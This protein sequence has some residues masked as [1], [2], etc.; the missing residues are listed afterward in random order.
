VQESASPHLQNVLPVP[1]RRPI[2][3]AALVSNNSKA[4]ERLA[5][6]LSAVPSAAADGTACAVTLLAACLLSGNLTIAA[7]VVR[8]FGTRLYPLLALDGDIRPPS[9]SFR[10]VSGGRS[11][12]VGLDAAV[13]PTASPTLGLGLGMAMMGT[14]TTAAAGVA[15]VNAT[16]TTGGSTTRSRPHRVPGEVMMTTSPVLGRR[17]LPPDSTARGAVGSLG[18]G[19]DAAVG[20]TPAAGETVLPGGS[21]SGAAVVGTGTTV[22]EDRRLSDA[23]SSGAGAGAQGSS[24][25]RHGSDGSDRSEASSAGESDSDSGR[26]DSEDE[27]GEEGDGDGDDGGTDL[28]FGVAGA[29]SNLVWGIFGSRSSDDAAEPDATMHSDA[30]S[31]G[32]SG[33]EGDD[34][35]DGDGSTMTGA[36]SGSGTESDIGAS[37]ASHV[38]EASSN[39]AGHQSPAA[40]VRRHSK[41]TCT[42]APD[43]EGVGTAVQRPPECVAR[44]PAENHHSRSSAAAASIQAA[45][46]VVAQQRDIEGAGAGVGVG[47][48]D[49]PGA[50]PDPTPQDAH[51]LGLLRR[52][53]YAGV[54]HR[55]GAQ[56]SSA[57]RVA[58]VDEAFSM[59]PR[60]TGGLLEEVFSA[61]LT[62]ILLRAATALT[63]DDCVQELVQLVSVLRVPLRFQYLGT[64]DV[65]LSHDVKFESLF[66][67][68]TL[69]YAPRTRIVL[70]C[71]HPCPFSLCL[72]VGVSLLITTCNRMLLTRLWTAGCPQLCM[73]VCDALGEG[74]AADV[75]RLQLQ[76]Q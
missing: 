10:R 23:G 62:P 17:V 28:T 8:F 30:D 14:T 51:A 55:A 31:D 24:D 71:C 21:G 26:S 29:L 20:F 64:T 50:F 11:V 54:S 60:W 25:E 32:G 7:D 59:I 72:W 73:L 57:T 66:D 53:L 9:M 1:P 4:A 46:G 41:D 74:V 70:T 61:Y 69:M 75:S 2:P 36:G 18:V 16:T 76:R 42:V 13:A 44:N 38:D 22:G 40:V 58:S 43:P 33:G 39:D 6:A 15:V 37:P 12:D 27:S 63:V 35:G 3:A 34:G 19:E 56:S 47:M 45:T 52:S 49:V 65:S 48:Q 68:P 5:L 67:P